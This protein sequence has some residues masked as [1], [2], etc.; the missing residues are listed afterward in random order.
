MSELTK[1]ELV[2]QVRAAQPKTKEQRNRIVCVLIGHSRIVDGC[3]GEVYC[4]RCEA[5][6]ADQLMSSYNDAPQSVRIGHNCATCRK[7]YKQ[8]GWRD[9]LYAP[10]PFTKRKRAA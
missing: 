5:K 7:N 9:K 8:M 6:I 1:S 3:M 2:S 10:N 4:G